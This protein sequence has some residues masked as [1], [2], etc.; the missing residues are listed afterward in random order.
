MNTKT[1]QTNELDKTK[2]I[3]KKRGRKKTIKRRKINQEKWEEEDKDDKKRMRKKNWKR[4]KIDE[5]TRRYRKK[6]KCSQK[7]TKRI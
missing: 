7:R 6:K 3:G 2:K 5:D 1:N 4:K